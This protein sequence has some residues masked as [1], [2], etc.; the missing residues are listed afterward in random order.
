MT[1]YQTSA[2]IKLIKLISKISEKIVKPTVIFTKL[3]P[4]IVEIVFIA[5]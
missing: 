4:E 5:I 1:Y 3:I 2:Y